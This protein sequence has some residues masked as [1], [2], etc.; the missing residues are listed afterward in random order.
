M[1]IVIYLCINM[2]KERF[3]VRISYNGF[4]ET[5]FSIFTFHF[6]I[7]IGLST[8]PH[9]IFHFSICIGLSANTLFNF[10]F[11]LRPCRT[12]FK[13]FNYLHRHRNPYQYSLIKMAYTCIYSLIKLAKQ[14]SYSLIYYYGQK[15]TVVRPVQI[16]HSCVPNLQVLKTQI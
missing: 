11:E 9:F 5:F 7:C 13:P 6:S 14:H 10:Q 3:Q 2:R 15:S 8:N 1:S 4:S 12:L 16:W